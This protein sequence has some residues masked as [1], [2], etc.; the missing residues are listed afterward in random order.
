MRRTY[1]RAV[2]TS[3]MTPRHHAVDQPARQ[4][5]RRTD[6][7]AP[8]AQMA[9]A[10]VDRFVAGCAQAY[11]APDETVLRR[12]TGPVTQL[13][14][15][16]PGQRH[17]PARHGRAAGGGFE[18]E[19]GDLFPVGA[20]MGAR[21]GDRDLHRQRGHLLP[22][23]AGRRGA[24]AGGAERAVRRLP[25][26]PRACSSSSCRAARC[27]RPTPRRRWPSSR[28]RRRWATL[29]RK[30]PVACSPTTPLA[31]ALAAD[32][33]AAHRLGAGGR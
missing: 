1:H 25:E 16:A 11:F 32:A 29:P 31:Q 10:H 9:P 13:L 7:H 23:A 15:H 27:R 20:V 8:F 30:P 17:R 6:A 26:P 14:L 12:P 33:R 22:A 24:G 4:P 28:S 5:A 3:P 19:A 18:Y 2:D 21:A